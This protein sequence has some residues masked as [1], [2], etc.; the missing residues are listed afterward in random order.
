MFEQMKQSG[1]APNTCTYNVMLC[2]ICRT[3]DLHAVKQFTTEVEC[4]NVEIDSV[5]VNAIAFL[6]KS[7]R[8]DSAAAMI[9]DMLNLGMKPTTKTCSLI[10]QSIDYKLVLEDNTA[11]TVESDGSESSSD[12]LVCSA[13]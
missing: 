8:I 6:M 2:G 10:A 5:L 11:A 12:L 13:S 3:R 4:T 9:G 1:I 7:Q